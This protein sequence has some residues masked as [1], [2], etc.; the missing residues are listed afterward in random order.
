MM[1][2]SDETTPGTSGLEQDR[3]GAQEGTGLRS[4]RI[5]H[6]DLG[7]VGAGC[8]VSEKPCCGGTWGEGR[9]H[10]FFLDCFNLLSG[11]GIHK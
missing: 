10:N 3:R 5:I 2:E 8:R 11:L 6:S 4:R 7:G 1:Q 9:M